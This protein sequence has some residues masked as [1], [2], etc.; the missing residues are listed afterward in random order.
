VRAVFVDTGA[1]IALI[2]RDDRFHGH[3]R[4]YYDKLYADRAGLLTTN[5]VV[6]ETATRLRYDVGLQAALDFRARID[7][8]GLI[9]KGRTIW[10]D[11]RLEAQGWR[12]MSQYADIPLSLADATSAAAAQ[13]NH[14][15]DVF[16]FDKHFAA[17]GFI[18][19]PIIS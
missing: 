15:T 9:G 10:V 19:A 1:W 11:E 5:Y 13:V 6:A 18:V 17:L 12:I 3:A 8:L 4:Q 14:I 2:K 16:G 7:A